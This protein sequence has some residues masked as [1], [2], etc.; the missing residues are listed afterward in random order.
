MDIQFMSD[1]YGCAVYVVNYISRRQK[2]VSEL[3]RQARAEARKQNSSI[4]QQVREIDSTFS[5]N[6]EIS[7]HEAVYIVFQHPMRK[8]SRQIVLVNTSPPDERGEI[9]KPVNDI[10]EL[11]DDFEE[12]FT[13]GLI[14]KIR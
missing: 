4:K 13:S 11:D 10:K 14:K 9:L 7:A 5:N 8:A 2:G 12:I 6:D 3:L 1:V